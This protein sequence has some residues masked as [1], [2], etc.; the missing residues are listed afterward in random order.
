ML[1]RHTAYVLRFS[2]AN[3]IPS[4]PAFKIAQPAWMCSC[5]LTTYISVHMYNLHLLSL[6]LLSCIERKIIS[7]KILV[8]CNFLTI[9]RYLFL[10][11]LI[12]RNR[13][14]T[15]ESISKLFLKLYAIPYH[16]NSLFIRLDDKR[17][18]ISTIYC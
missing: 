4:L 15:K 1:F 12:F 5:T 3:K 9:Y 2:K 13:S 8:Q 11:K 10:K 18:N 14:G 17:M 6:H 7:Y 16:I